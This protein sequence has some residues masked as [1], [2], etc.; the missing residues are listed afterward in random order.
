MNGYLLTIRPEPSAVPADDDRIIIAAYKPLTSG[1]PIGRRFA[2]VLKDV[3]RR[4]LEV[5]GLRR[6]FKTCDFFEMSRSQ[7][8]AVRDILR[9]IISPP[10]ADRSPA[11]ESDGTAG[12]VEGGEGE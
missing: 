4:H 9:Q 6:R 3:D 1:V 12:I 2:G 5:A 10:D 8:A 7:Y 11:C